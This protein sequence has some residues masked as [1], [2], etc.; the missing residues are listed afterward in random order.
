[1]TRTVRNYGDWPAAIGVEQLVAGALRFGTLKTKDDNVYWCEQ[2]AVEAGRGVIMRWSKNKGVEELLPPPFSAR[3]KVHEYGGGEFAVAEGITYFVNAE[4][5]QIYRMAEA[6]TPTRLTG[7]AEF[8]FADIEFDAA[9]NRLIAVAEQH[10]SDAR[11]PANLLVAIDLSRPKNQNNLSIISS[12]HDFYAAPRISPDGQLIAWLQWDL[13]SMP[14]QHAEL[15]VALNKSEITNSK[16]VAGGNLG[17]AFQPSWSEDGELYYISDQNGSGDL[18]K[19][20]PTSETHEQVSHQAGDALRPQWV[21]GMGSYA[22]LDNKIAIVSS[23]HNGEHQLHKIEADGE[24]LVPLAAK[25][26]EMPRKL[27]GE[28]AGELVGEL[29]SAGDTNLAG[30]I[31]T[32]Y[33]AP[34][35]AICDLVQNQI[36]IIRKSSELQFEKEDISIGSIKKFNG[37]NN[38]DVYGVYYPPASARYIAEEG[39]LPP[40]ILT[41]HGGPTGMSDRGLKV[42]TQF[43]TNRGFAVFDIDYSG[44]SGYG[45]AY[46]KRLDGAWGTRD[47][48]DIIQA[49]K[50]L[51]SNDLADNDKLN[52]T[53]GSA[54]G[55]TC[56]RALADTNI[57]KCA[58]CLYPVTD[59]GQLLDITHKFEHGYL[60]SLTGT[61]LDTAKARLAERSILTQITE[62]NSPVLFF[63]G[64][65]DKVVPPSQPAAV[66]RALKARGIETQIVNFENEGHGFRNAGTIQKVAAMEENFF[67]QHIGLGNETH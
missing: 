63:Q 33:D 25:S 50:F 36:S 48:V 38:E 29:A 28:L 19:W 5:Q 41:I 13:P 39:K 59:L 58:S 32:D 56:L 17:A 12:A 6:A 46:R 54:G 49:A 1:M 34:S 2:R 65:E 31:T 27:A 55:Y 45:A 15:V 62:I 40:C 37:A 21:F 9:N 14:W 3:S 66:Y 60:Y 61:T 8:R 43:W 24:H 53:G 10:E 23:Y 11:F 47:V 7:A 52:I 30:L 18:F 64:L 35:I 44:S 42:K 57:F 22:L 4:D 67:R 51:T 26:L 16:Y 20:H